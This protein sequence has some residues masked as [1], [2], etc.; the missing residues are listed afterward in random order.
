MILRLLTA[1]C[2]SAA[3]TL[4]LGPSVSAGESSGSRTK[5]LYVFGDSLSDSANVYALTGEVETPSP[6]YF[7]GR[8]SNG[9]VWVENLAELLGLEIDFETPVTVDPLANNQAVGG[10]FTDT[11]NSNDDLIEEPN[12]NGI[13]SQVENFEDAGGSFRRK[14]L[15]IVW[16]GAN[17]YIFDL[18]AADPEVVVEDL[19]EVIE[20]LADLGGRRFLV[21]N[22]PDLGRTPF[23]LLREDEKER[24]LLS[25]LLTN[26][27]L[28]HNAA[29]AKMLDELREDMPHT[30]NVELDIFTTFDALLNGVTF[31]NSEIPCL[32]QDEFRNRFPTPA[33]GDP[34]LSNPTGT[35]FWD[36]VHPTAAAHEVIAIFAYG[37]VTGAA[38]R[39][40][41]ADDD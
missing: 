16:G 3:L 14:D 17:N 21:P 8:Y 13:T 19:E 2:L 41:E 32:I 30:V 40:A 28:A 39:V 12:N 25:A 24:E 20:E 9:P 36:L 7:D 15:V 22:L 31:P 6:P 11:R 23:A 4:G 37:A 38:T 33:C 10:A 26:L 5:T 35:L 34:P 27:T 18:F 29:L 1:V